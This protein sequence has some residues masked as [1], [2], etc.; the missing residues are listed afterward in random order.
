MSDQRCRVLALDGGGIRGAFTAA[1]LEALDADLQ[2]DH[3]RAD[4]VR[5]VDHFD[6]I[7]GTSTGGLLALG[8][9]L[10]I[11]PS[12][13]VRF[14]EDHAATIF[15]ERG[16]AGRFTATIKQ[17]L[18]TKYSGEELTEALT[19]VFGDQLL[20]DAQTR[21]V[22]PAYDITMGRVFVFKTAHHPRFRYDVDIPAVQIAR[23]T[24]AAPTFF[25]AT[26]LESHRNTTYVDG[27]VW[28][29]NPSLIG[30]T[31]AVEFLG[32]APEQVDILNIGTTS[33]IPDFA[34]KADAGVLD[35]NVGLVDLMMAAQAETSTNVASLFAGSYHRVDQTRSA[36]QVSMDD[37]DHLQGLIAAGRSVAVLKDNYETV[38]QS[39]LNGRLAAPFVPD[40]EPDPP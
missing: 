2:R 20:G 26:V 16:L 8:L 3:G 18:S 22:I 40:H 4:P 24:S 17:A 27:G 10:G 23:C 19:S 5:L 14:Y 13:L 37:L 7:C 25:P 33:K 31:E 6:L 15:P 35:W 30:L 36:D 21:L 12:E 39:F 32:Y 28:A 11:T 34:D 9:A 38:S 1:V 29:N